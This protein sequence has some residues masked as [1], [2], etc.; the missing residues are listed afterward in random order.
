MTEQDKKAERKLQ[1][2]LGHVFF[3]SRKYWV[4]YRVRNYV[5]HRPNTY[6][7][8]FKVKERAEAFIKEL[9]KREDY[10]DHKLSIQ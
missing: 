10:I 6:R 8:W 5:T 7:K 4:T 9:Q 3:G 2:Y 1:N